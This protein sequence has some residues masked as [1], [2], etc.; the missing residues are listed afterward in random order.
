M[1]AVFI[2]VLSILELAT[3]LLARETPSASRRAVSTRI[4]SSGSASL[5][6]RPALTNALDRAS[7]LLHD[8]PLRGKPAAVMGASTD[9][10]GALWAQ[11]ELQKVLSALGADVVQ[12]V[13]AV[14]SVAAA[15]T[16]EGK[17]ADP[18]LASDLRYPVGELFRRGSACEAA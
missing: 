12:E 9:V 5:H 15:F 16:S 17:L 13:L 10:F 18:Q 4:G 3:I 6:V 8:N 11:A 1:L 14:P 7:R 2:V